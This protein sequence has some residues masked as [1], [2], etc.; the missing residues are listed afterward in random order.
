M[1]IMMFYFLLLLVC[2]EFEH[3]FSLL[4]EVERQRDEV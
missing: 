2:C 1:M 3:G 4:V